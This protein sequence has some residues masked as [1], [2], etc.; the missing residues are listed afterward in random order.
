MWICCQ[1]GAREHYSVPRALHSRNQLGLLVTDV[2]TKGQTPSGV[3][4]DA[5]TK[6]RFHPDLLHANVT[7]WNWSYRSFEL[8]LR[9]RRKGWD[10][11]TARNDW[12]QARTLSALRLYRDAH[13]NETVVLFAYSYAAR[14]PFEFAKKERWSTVLGQIDGGWGEH[15]M[16]G[17]I[18]SKLTGYQNDWTAGPDRYWDEWREECSLADHIVVNSDW[19]R[20]CL[21]GEGIKASKLETIPLA[22]EPPLE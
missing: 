16:I 2:W 19:S 6:G 5:R 10:R 17:D 4:T 21:M 20:R 9:L 7:S 3:L 13:P 1:L 22:Y 14:V 8:S 18:Q 15:R 11:I 12:F